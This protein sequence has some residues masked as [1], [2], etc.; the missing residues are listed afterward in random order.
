[1]DSDRINAIAFSM[2]VKR[3]KILLPWEQAP[4]KDIFGCKAPLIPAA[5]W[6]PEPGSAVG[7]LE[8]D[9]TVSKGHFVGKD[10]MDYKNNVDS[11]ASFRGS[12][13]IQ[14]FGTMEGGYFGQLSTHCIRAS[15]SWPH[16][17][18]RAE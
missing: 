13:V 11:L 17:W 4:L 5:Q 15:N 1:M 10:F 6:V 16:V 9:K 14:G 3:S 7:S 8:L 12:K 2:G 18:R